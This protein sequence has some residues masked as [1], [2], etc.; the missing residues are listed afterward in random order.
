MSGLMAWELVKGPPVPIAPPAL[1]PPHNSASPS[2]Q[3]LTHQTTFLPLLRCCGDSVRSTFPYNL[4]CSQ[5]A[6]LLCQAF[7]AVLET[8]LSSETLHLSSPPPLS[9]CGG[10]WKGRGQGRREGMSLTPRRWQKL[11]QSLQPKISARACDVHMTVL[12][13]QQ[14]LC[15]ICGLCKHLEIPN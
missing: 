10:P 14:P 11:L 1:L 12:I 6:L 15:L 4:G 5:L 13:F 8:R 7:P 2:L 9:L 3:L